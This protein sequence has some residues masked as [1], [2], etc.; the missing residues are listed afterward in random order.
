MNNENLE[1]ILGSSNI[2]T[3]KTNNTYTNKTNNTYTNKTNNTNYS[4]TSNTMNIWSDKIT[5]EMVNIMIQ[6]NICVLK[7]YHYLTHSIDD[8]P[9]NITTL[10]LFNVY[11]S[12]LNDLPN[13]F[14]GLFSAMASPFSRF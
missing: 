5:D 12:Q 1:K 2:Y 14:N 6:Y 3:N 13:S 7:I 9:N 10:I 11:S 8:L 4:I